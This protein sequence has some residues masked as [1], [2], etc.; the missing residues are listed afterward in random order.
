[1]SDL[2]HNPDEPKTPPLRKDSTINVTHL[3][4]PDIQATGKH[5]GTVKTLA[6]A[7][8]RT[9]R[10]PTWFVRSRTTSAFLRARR[11]QNYDDLRLKLNSRRGDHVTSESG[12]NGRTEQQYD[13]K[14]AHRHFENGTRPEQQYDLRCSVC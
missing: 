4:S 2:S 12:E 11:A 10:S 7:R 14:N 8:R 6:N 9:L 3:A 5:A 13:A 1:V